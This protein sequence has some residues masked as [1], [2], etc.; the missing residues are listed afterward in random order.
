V[1]ESTGKEGKG[2]VPITGE[3]LS[4]ALGVDRIAVT[5][6]LGGGEDGQIR[7]A[8]NGI[9]AAHIDLSD[10]NSIGAEFFRWEVA[11]TAAGV[12]LGINPFDEPNV[13]QAKDATKALLEAYSVQRRLP[14]PVPLAS[15]EGVRLSISRNAQ[16]QLGNGDPFA[17]LRL[18]RPGDY[19]CLLAYVP[20]DDAT[21]EPLLAE[22]RAAIGTR[23]GCATMFGYGPR[24][25]HS[26]GQLHKGGPNTG[27]FIILTSEPA[28]DLPVPGEP[29]TFGILET[30]QAVGDFQSLESTGRRAL[31]VHLP[32]REPDLVRRVFAALLG[33]L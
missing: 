8:A 3:P 30:A 20:P 6:G 14:L 31:S 22:L 19:V 5:L 18:A 26:T 4:T 25:L 29:F 32:R 17:F 2:V 13:Q 1:A 28:S 7:R 12:L 24:Y 33:A 16:Q 10:V 27:V 21:L 15:R 11:T 23:T 9:P